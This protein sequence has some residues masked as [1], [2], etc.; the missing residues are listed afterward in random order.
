VV[1]AFFEP[2]VGLYSLAGALVV[3]GGPTM[4]L[5]HTAPSLV[6]VSREETARA[7]PARPDRRP[8]RKRR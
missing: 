5:S 3:L 7:H 6:T 4:F 2:A 1:D 8:R